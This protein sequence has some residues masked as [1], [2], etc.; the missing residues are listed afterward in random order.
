MSL[1]ILIVEDEAITALDI[2]RKLEYWGHNVLDIAH[3]GSDAIEIAL[4]TKPD[5][6]LMDII[7]KG[8][9][10]GIETAHEI[11]KKCDIPVIYLTAHSEEKIMERAKYTEPY[12]YLIKP[13]DDKELFFAL[14]SA[15]YK[16]KADAKLKKVN[17]ALRMIS[18]CNQSIVRIKDKNELLNEIC[19]LIVKE[20]G[21]Y[22]AWVGMVQEDQFKSVVPVAQYGFDEGFLKSVK[23]SWGN[24]KY[25]GGPAGKSI[26]TSKI[27]ITRN[28]VEDPDFEP[29]KEQAIKRKYNSAIALPLFV[30]EKVV[31]CLSIYSAE[32]EAYDE[33]EIDLL[34][35]LAGDISYYLESLKT[36]KE[37]DIA[38]KKLK[39]S[40][41][42]LKDIINHA[43]FGAHSY[44][45]N[46]N[47]DLIFVNANLSANEILNIDHKVLFGKTVKEAFPGLADTHLP[48]IYHK[49]ALNGGKHNE[50]SVNY[51]NEQINGIFEINVVNTGKNK[52]TVFFRDVTESKKAE[53][54]L[55]ESEI[56]YRTIFENSE[57]GIYQSTAE[58][59]Y[60]QVN[61]ALARMLG[62]DSPESVINEVTDISTFYVNPDDRKKLKKYL[63]KK[64]VMKDYHVE[65]FL[66]NGQKAWV[67]ITEKAIRD[68]NGKIL[69]FEG[70]ARDIT[71]KKKIEDNLKLSE[72]KYRTM[73]ETSNEGIWSLDKDFKTTFVNHKLAQMLGYDVSDIMGKSILDF[74]FEEDI[75]EQKNRIELRKKGISQH[76]TC[77]FLCQNG[78]TLWTLVSATPLKD[79]NGEFKGSFAMF[80]SLNEIKNIIDE[81]KIN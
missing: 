19:R 49:I 68:E 16:Y 69:Y 63:E 17:R 59:R 51:Q 30:E 52:M 34:Q 38:L 61:P 77:K 60:I 73:V 70:I 29:W 18:D 39:K 80:T 20:G 76:Y 3:S 42:K 5:L 2:K 62:F 1:N 71:R 35:E 37:K 28:L 13:I 48:E 31:G 12:G 36:K 58:G 72:E 64:D 41:E 74:M 44:E 43:P 15:I 11:K 25:S 21:Y 40:E 8:E 54:A 47:G 9:L 32:V 55:K 23:I 26:K 53:M 50:T 6:I 81:I 24:N 75:N 46:E 67:S 56:R 33:N 65:I 14:E 10:D 57:E 22:L 78:D 66:K 4:K 79:K 45:I 27:S 7:I